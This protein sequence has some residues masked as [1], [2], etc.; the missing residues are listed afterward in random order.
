[1]SYSYEYINKLEQFGI[2]M[3]N[4]KLTD[5]DGI[6]P[7]VLVP[8]S[9]YKNEIS[10]E[11]LNKI[12]KDIISQQTEIQSSNIIKP[13]EIIESNTV[14]DNTAVID[15]IVID[16]IIINEQSSTEI[17]EDNS[18]I[19]NTTI[20]SDEETTENILNTDIV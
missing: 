13:I 19:D 9:L 17:I 2:S 8:V 7:D 1:M 15:D 3:F 12:A 18:S 16:T 5:T 20:V 10:E 6:L 4:L 11:K 14:I